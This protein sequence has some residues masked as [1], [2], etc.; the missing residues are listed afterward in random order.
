[1]YIMVIICWWLLCLFCCFWG[2][3][4][5]VIVVLLELECGDG[6]DNYYDYD[7]LMGFIIVFYC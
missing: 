2:C 1:M 3:I 5:G 4:L 6:G 7:Y